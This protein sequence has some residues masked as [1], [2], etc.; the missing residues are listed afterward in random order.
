MDDSC[1]FV[2]IL[3]DQHKGL[4]DDTQIKTQP[5]S[6][7]AFLSVSFLECFGVQSDYSPHANDELMVI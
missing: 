4:T 1:S 6:N 2:H 3:R 5:T 7:S